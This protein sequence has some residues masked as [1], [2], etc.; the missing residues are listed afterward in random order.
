MF[1][2]NLC[3]VCH[4][5]RSFL[6]AQHKGHAFLSTVVQVGRCV[7]SQ[8]VQEA[9]EHLSDPAKRREYDSVDEF[10]DGLPESCAPADFYKVGSRD[11]CTCRD[12]KSRLKRVAL[13]EAKAPRSGG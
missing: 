2:G 5:T 13:V 1:L 11:T 10:D 6:R 9:Y 3:K 8:Q 4:D 12:T 7:R